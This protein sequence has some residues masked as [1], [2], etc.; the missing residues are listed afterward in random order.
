MLGSAFGDPCPIPMDLPGSPAWG[1]GRLIPPRQGFGAWWPCTAGEPAPASSDPS[2]PKVLE[3]LGRVLGL[4]QEPQRD[5]PGPTCPLTRPHPLPC[6][7]PPPQP[8]LCSL[9]SPARA[10]CLLMRTA[11]RAAALRARQ[12]HAPNTS[13]LSARLP[14][15]PPPFTEPLAPQS[16]PQGQPE[17]QCGSPALS[18]AR[19]CLQAQTDAPCFPLWVTAPGR[20]PAACLWG[21]LA[22]TVV[23]A[24]VCKDR[25]EQEEEGTCRCVPVWQSMR[26]CAHVQEHKHT[27]HL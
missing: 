16:W 25:C 1:V 6:L 14:P 7:R 8:P 20:I 10:G 2:Y 5:S 26:V 24:C 15:Q 11:L 4:H 19:P 17:G 9:P 12:P 18:R 3:K 22:Y 21:L 23:P 27:V 13:S